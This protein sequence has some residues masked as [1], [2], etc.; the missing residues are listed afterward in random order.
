MQTEFPEVFALSVE[1]KLELL[2]EL[3]DSIA[4]SPQDIPVPE[5]QI[6][7]LDRRKHEYERN[8]E[9]GLSWD[10]VKQQ[11]LN[12]HEQRTHHPASGER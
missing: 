12:K 9:I 2:G 8:P 10:V 1:K 3:W 6:D 11:I 4:A 5:W 7:E